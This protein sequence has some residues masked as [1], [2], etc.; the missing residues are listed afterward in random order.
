[1]M[2]LYALASLM[3]RHGIHFDFKPMIL[4]AGIVIPWLL[5]NVVPAIL[6]RLAR[7]LYVE[8]VQFPFGTQTLARPIDHVMIT[9]FDVPVLGPIIE[10]G[11]S[12]ILYW[13]LI[14]ETTVGY[15][16]ASSIIYKR[17]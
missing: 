3:E 1:M 5:F 8:M 14:L 10:G 15:I 16:V 6:P 7:R 9:L 13:L 2:G 4:L 12:M 17:I 11:A